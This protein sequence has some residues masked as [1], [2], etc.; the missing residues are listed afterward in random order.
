MNPRLRLL[1]GALADAQAYKGVA[2]FSVG[3]L[4]LTLVTAVAILAGSAYIVWL[5]WPTLLLVGTFSGGFSFW[6]MLY[7]VLAMLRVPLDLARVRG[8]FSSEPYAQALAMRR[9]L[10]AGDPIIAPAMA[11]ILDES[12]PSLF[13]SAPTSAE[14]LVVALPAPLLISR[15]STIMLYISAMLLL[16]MAAGGAALA[17]SI[18]SLPLDQ[19]LSAQAGQIYL[20]TVCGGL[21]FFGLLLFLQARRRGRRRQF[22][23]RGV[24]V[25]LDDLGMSFRQPV[26]SKRPRHIAWAD[27]RGLGR[28]TYK[29]KYTRE[30]N[31]YI[32]DSEEQ[33][34]VWEE[35]PTER[36]ASEPDRQRIAALQQDSWN[37]VTA[38]TRR[39]KLPIRDLSGALTTLANTVSTNS[40]FLK[41]AYD[42]AITERDVEMATALWRL[43][44]PHAR[45]QPRALR[46]L[47]AAASTP[48][49]A[50]LPPMDAPVPP[51]TLALA[52][53]RATQ[54][55]IAYAA[56]QKKLDELLQVAHALIPYYPTEDAPTT[57]RR[58]RRA[59]RRE[60][61]RRS[62]ILQVG[63]V[64][65]L[66]IAA[67]FVG[68]GVY[69]HDEQST[70]KLLHALPQQLAAEN[71]AYFASF[72]S[73]Q[74]DWTVQKASKDDP[75]AA[76]FVNSAYQVSCNDPNSAAIF[77]IP[78][79]IDGDIAIAV[80]LSIHGVK[81]Q[82]S[83]Y[84]AGI[85]FDASDNG[86]EFSTFGID[87]QGNWN[88]SHYSVAT[89][90]NNPWNTVDASVSDAL[91]TGDNATNT[92][93]LI[94]HGPVYLLYVNGALV[95]RYYDS[96]HMMHPTGDVGVYIDACDIVASFNDFTFYPVPPQLA[97]I[98]VAPSLPSWLA[99]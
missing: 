63:V 99:N 68:A 41:D 80:T 6:G 18:L 56:A 20:V 26:W 7:P 74:S 89:D 48:A 62:L 86:D 84:S 70:T 14:S 85:L 43:R 10:A 36:Y 73:P 50:S 16:L 53:R 51:T 81:T 49:P 54:L 40:T 72:V 8:L 66:L 39:T 78:Q 46:K 65:L 91:R 13:A 27:M 76:A 88:L 35:P 21:T 64:G 55:S 77:T 97:A 37:L 82:D 52:K 98:P 90:A 71:P 4:I 38:I 9:A 28:Y 69:S 83:G 22:Q 23:R 19:L 67:P 32:I 30:H 47:T 57:P 93:L 11:A 59:L 61:M 12:E 3:I 45:K 42:A 60:R 94:R 33:T 5:Y 92:L 96:G 29:D 34:L 15:A 95:D 79:Y 24:E 2:R 31:L 17:S 25:A 75:T 1:L 44:H 87:E 58:F